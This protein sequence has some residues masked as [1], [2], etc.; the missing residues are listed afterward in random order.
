MISVMSKLR[1]ST[2]PLLSSLPDV[3]LAS[4]STQAGITTKK[5]SNSSFGKPALPLSPVPLIDLF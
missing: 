3:Y 4:L 1:E 5:S 2:I